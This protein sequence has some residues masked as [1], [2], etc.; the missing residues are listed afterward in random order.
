MNDFI[1]EIPE[2]KG[3]EEEDYEDIRVKLVHLIVKYRIFRKNDLEALFGRT[4]IHNQH[5]MENGK[6]E[7]LEKIFQELRDDLEK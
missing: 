2:T 5:M 1:H 4:L 6:F 7:K 3:K